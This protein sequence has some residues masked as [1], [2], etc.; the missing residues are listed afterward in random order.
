M[1][2]SISQCQM[3]LIQLHCNSQLSFLPV[4]LLT[5]KVQEAARSDEALD[6]DELEDDIEPVIRQPLST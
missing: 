5:F 6:E 3:H 1:A 4:V 2:E